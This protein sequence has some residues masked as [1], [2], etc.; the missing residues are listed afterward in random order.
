VIRGEVEVRKTCGRK[1]SSFRDGTDHAI[2][3]FDTV[4]NSCNS[5]LQVVSNRYRYSYG[6]KIKYHVP[7]E[8]KYAIQDYTQTPHNNPRHSILYYSTQDKCKMK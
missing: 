5:T 1:N 6:S 3:Q 8:P 2:P 4:V 7:K